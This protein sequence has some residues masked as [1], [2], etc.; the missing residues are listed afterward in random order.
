MDLKNSATR[1]EIKDVEKRPADTVPVIFVSNTDR[2]NNIEKSGLWQG[3]T[4]RIV[5]IGLIIVF[6][7]CA[8]FLRRIITPM[9][10][11]CLMIFYLKPVVFAIQNKWNISHK[12]SVII[13]FG[14]FLIIVLGISALCGLS[15]YNQALNLYDLINKSLENLPASILD[16][17]GGEDSPLGKFV[18]EYLDSSRNT[19]LNQQIRSA[20]QNFGGNL[21]S[22]VQSITSKIG[23]FFFIYGFSFFVVWEMKDQNKSHEG[24][25]IAGYEHDI[26]MGKKHLTFIWRRFLWGQMILLLISLVVYTVLYFVLGIKYAL[27]LG[28]VVS[29]TRMI[30]YIGSFFAWGVVALVAL[31]QG[32]T[33]FGMKPFSYAVM[34]VLISFLIDKFMD[35]FIQPKYMAQTLKVHPAAVLTS[36]LICGRTM[37]FLGIFLSAPLAAT[38]KLVLSYIFRKL[39]DKDPWSNIET[40]SESLTMKEYINKNR[41]QIIKMYDKLKYRTVY[42]KSHLAKITG[43]KKHG[44]NGIKD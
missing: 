34:V 25:T 31:F 36:A 41:Q 21:I 15:I 26:E 3:S 17:L 23:W 32:Y 43:G 5:I 35:G 9:I 33:I 16:F 1:Q 13:V 4:K 12:L 8:F 10:L 37:G 18:K 40:V 14:F 6:L 39:G 29:L 2:D 44:S 24:F 19:E 38:L 42:L 20:F 28:V 7:V 11:S 22:F 27:I 30:P